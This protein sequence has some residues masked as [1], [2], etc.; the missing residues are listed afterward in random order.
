MNNHHISNTE[1]KSAE[2][3]LL[4][5]PFSAAQQLFTQNV[6]KP[7]NYSLNDCGLKLKNYIINYINA[8]LIIDSFIIM[9]EYI[10]LL[11]TTI[12][13]NNDRIERFENNSLS[14]LRFNEIIERKI[15]VSKK[16]FNELKKF[17]RLLKI[18]FPFITLSK[19]YYDAII[20]EKTKWVYYR[21][22]I[23]SLA[24]F[25]TAENYRKLAWRN[26]WTR[27]F[28]LA[29][30]N[31]YIAIE[32]YEK[33]KDIL[34]IESMLINYLQARR[35]LALSLSFLL[36]NNISQ[37]HSEYNLELIDKLLIKFPQS[38]AE[39]TLE[40][41]KNIQS[42]IITTSQTND[43]AK[44][45]DYLEKQLNTSKAA[46]NYY[47]LALAYQNYGLY[48]YAK[49]DLK[50]ARKY[51][52]KAYNS[53]SIHPLKR[54][55][56]LLY[57]TLILMDENKIKEAINNLE[58]IEKK[59]SANDI[60]DHKIYFNLAL[61]EYSNKNYAIA[62]NHF[63]KAIE[64][65]DRNMASIKDFESRALFA[66]KRARL[67][68]KAIECAAR[69]SKKTEY[70][71]NLID[72]AKSRSFNEIIFNK[73]NLSVENIKIPEFKQLAETE[74]K[75]T[76]A[77]NNYFYS[78][79]KFT[80][81]NAANN[82][83]DANIILKKIKALE[84]NKNE[85][86]IKIKYKNTNLYSQIAL[87][88]ININA[89]KNNIPE[90]SIIIDYYAT[91][92]ILLII[93]ISG[94]FIKMKTVDISLSELNSAADNFINFI[95]RFKYYSIDCANALTLKQFN[96]FA[97]TLYE[98]LVKPIEKEILDFKNIIISP[99]SHLHNISFAALIDARAKLLIES[100]NISYI[101][102][103]RTLEN[104]NIEK[105][106]IKECRNLII[107]N[108]TNDLYYSE[109]EAQY[110][111]KK[112]KTKS[113]VNKRA[114]KNNFLRNADKF[115]IIHFACHAD[116]RADAPEFSHILLRN[117][118][119]QFVNLE[120]NEIINLNLSN[121]ELLVLSSCLTGVSNIIK[122]DELVSLARAFLFAGVKC[123]IVSLWEIDD[124]ITA[125]L[126]MR[127][128]DMLLQTGNSQYSL[129]CAQLHIKEK[130]V[131]PYYWTGFN[132]IG[133]NEFKN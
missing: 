95:N 127:F 36:K 13:D 64:Y 111:S 110:I 93:L 3:Y 120:I 20:T 49:K 101:P 50:S 65:N 7:R 56:M 79:T 89:I 85:L 60:F 100:F 104:L 28:E 29:G 118:H 119:N 55:E 25:E 14:P 112:M 27:N 103:L 125:E 133:L 105:R 109:I 4:T 42:L 70:I 84:T 61:C 21:K 32:H 113:F 90:N 1:Y 88:E 22:L 54:L 67:F 58:L 66:G 39:L 11:L 128:Y 52:E 87:P 96:W 35:G 9:P 115:E 23:V 91:E 107:A 47:Y 40:K 44:Y 98:M 117:E 45:L 68:N 51:F 6:E 26:N 12:K 131:Y 57:K 116:Y 122:G 129:K 34:D 16:L 72:K 73:N 78:K 94:Q 121:V 8:E 15:S 81:N 106:K 97:G 24:N 17:K 80:D 124:K 46:K 19:N 86:L 31:F 102:S 76:E 59:F 130:Y 33:I 30:K 5:I 126:M 41:L 123:V 37:N 62:M 99:N 10:S 83:N 38:R 108:A 43:E 75:L 74:T 63:E 53:K 114:T 82:N 69:A 71:I 77:R 18:E 92:N 132:V 2:Y 48:C